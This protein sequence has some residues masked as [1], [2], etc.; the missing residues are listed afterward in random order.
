MRR[1]ALSAH[2]VAIKIL[3]QARSF[4]E[5][6]LSREF[7]CLISRAL[8]EYIEARFGVHALQ[9]TTPEIIERLR[10]VPEP[11]VLERCDKLRD[12][13]E[14]C[15][16]ARIG[17]GSLSGGQIEAIHLWAWGFVGMTRDTRSARAS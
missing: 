8:R 1:R 3:D 14:H 12:L 13:L 17:D 2:D 6:H 10:H 16:R 15:D 7:A 5:P 9:R 11:A 4:M